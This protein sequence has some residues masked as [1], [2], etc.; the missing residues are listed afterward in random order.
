MDLFIAW[1]INGHWIAVAMRKFRRAAHRHQG[2]WRVSVIC[3][4]MNFAFDIRESRI[5]TATDKGAK[6]RNGCYMSK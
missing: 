2:L 4:A 1:N 5:R 6:R 3:I